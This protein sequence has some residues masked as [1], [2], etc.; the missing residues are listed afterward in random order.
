MPTEHEV[1]HRLSVQLSGDLYHKLQEHVP[2]GLMK[3]LITTILEDFVHLCEK[4]DSRILI[5][6]ILSKEVGLRDFL[7]KYEQQEKSDGERRQSETK[8]H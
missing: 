3:P 5:G 6:A 7:N 8:H 1:R 4:T 2:W